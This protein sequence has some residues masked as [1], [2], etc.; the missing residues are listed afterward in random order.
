MKDVRDALTA[1]G[2]TLKIGTSDVDSKMTAEM[3]EEAD[4]L[5]VNIHP[6][7]GG[8]TDPKTAASTYVTTTLDKVKG[9][10]SGRAEWYVGETGV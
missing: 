4:V 6:W 8:I 1:V 2:A 5:F 7:F 9:S 3:A 10:L